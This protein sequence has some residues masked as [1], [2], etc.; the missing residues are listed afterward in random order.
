MIGK[1]VYTEAPICVSDGL[2]GG[3][4]RVYQTDQGTYK[5]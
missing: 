1:Q 3:D 4:A 2:P 5:R